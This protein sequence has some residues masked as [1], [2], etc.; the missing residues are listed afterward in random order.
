L[1][2][3]NDRLKQR[4]QLQASRMREAGR[5]SFVAQLAYLG[6]LGLMIVLPMVAG[7][8]LGIALDSRQPGYSI[9]WTLGLILVG[10]V[11]GFGS[12]YAY[13]IRK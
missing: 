10:L 6:T 9:A 1:K 12:A 13:M 5:R 4:V 3:A 11:I 8:Y 2:R 7:A